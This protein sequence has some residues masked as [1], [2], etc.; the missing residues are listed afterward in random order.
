M[1]TE[2][3]TRSARIVEDIAAREPEAMGG[4][5]LFHP[6]CASRLK[7]SLG[8]KHQALAEAS[9]NAGSGIAKLLG[10]LAEDAAGLDGAQVAALRAALHRSLQALETVDTATACRAPISAADAL[11]LEQS[12]AL[13][14]RTAAAVS[15]PGGGDGAA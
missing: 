3:T 13:L 4:T 12:V 10:L 1:P 8:G 15:G 2:P 9:R 6:L 11:A 7:S 14:L 5:V